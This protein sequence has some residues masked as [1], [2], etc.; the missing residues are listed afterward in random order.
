MSKQ[1]QIEIERV[2]GKNYDE[3]DIPT[4]IRNRDEREEILD[5]HIR[6]EILVSQEE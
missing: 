1:E 6:A 4:F 2:C 3:N 5:D